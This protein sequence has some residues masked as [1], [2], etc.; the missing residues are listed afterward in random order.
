MVEFEKPAFDAAAFLANAGLGRR[1]VQ[2]A[3]KET[4][5]CARKPGGFRLLSSKRPRKDHGC[6][7]SREGS[8]HHTFLCR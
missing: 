3:P 2:L 6:F 7:R 1:I 5:F 8:H 4:F